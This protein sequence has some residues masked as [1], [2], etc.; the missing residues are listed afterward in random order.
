MRLTR[1]TA[2]VMWPDVPRGKVAQAIFLFASAG[3]R[4]IELA[5]NCPYEFWADGTFV[6]FGG[7]RCPPG[8]VEIDTWDASAPSRVLVRLHYMDPALMQVW[9][10]CLF[11]DPFL[12]DLDARSEWSCHEDVSL[13][14]AARIDTQ[15]G[16]Q[17]VVRA[18]VSPGRLLDLV[19]VDRGDWEAVTPSIQPLR[20]VPVDLSWTDRVRTTP[21]KAPF[22]P[23]LATDVF[24]CVREQPLDCISRRTYALPVLGPHRVELS[25]PLPT[26]VALVY[27]E[28]EDLRDV[29][30]SRN[31]SKVHLA[32]AFVPRVAR[33]APFGVR[34]CKYIHLV[35]AGRADGVELS[36]WRQH[37]LLEWKPVCSGDP[38]TAV[39]LQACRNNLVA[40]VDGGVVDTCWREQTQ[41]VGDLRMSAIALAKL[42]S[43]GLPVVERALAQ[44]ATSYE[45]GPG[46]VQGAWPVKFPGYRG[47]LMPTYHLAYC[48]TVLRHSKDPALR[49]LVVDSL[50][51]WRER[52]QR[53]DGFICGAPGWHFV[54]WDATNHEARG[55]R[56]GPPG[57]DWR[58]VPH[59]V[60]NAWFFEAC[61]AAGIDPGI[62]PGRLLDAFYDPAARSGR[63]YP[64]GPPSVHATAA[65]LGSVPVERE[66]LVSGLDRLLGTADLEKRVTL[67][68]GYFVAA[69]L[70]R[71]SPERAVRFV[72]SFYGPVA[73]RY[74]TLYEK[75]NAD[76]SMAHGWSVGIVDFLVE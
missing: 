21:R 16:S 27:T 56:W 36:A 2:N 25:N 73:E 28:V 15:L 45:P 31:R 66:T 72:K 19:R 22:E 34:G 4:R 74:G 5:S 24:S 7:C 68:Y 44:I 40:C 58:T 53:A 32:D 13:G 33:G 76:A 55:H 3:H 14:F 39:I 20:Y 23:H 1:G 29:Y 12:A 9:C 30:S 10:R 57:S 38:V 71:D 42:T 49:S 51:H 64:G 11:A 17:H 35:S 52:Y 48:L 54:D 70:A 47:T 61:A 18:P 65:L 46:M 50:T 59:A 69:A 6:G 43:N 67:Y 37:Y 26:G 63:L 8:K 75:T 41:W 62:G 60:V